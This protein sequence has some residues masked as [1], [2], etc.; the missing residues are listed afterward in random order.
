MKP[1]AF[2]R[3]EIVDGRAHW[4]ATYREDGG[5]PRADIWRDTEWVGQWSW[6]EQGFGGRIQRSRLRV[7]RGVLEKLA[8]AMLALLLLGCSSHAYS[9]GTP[10][11]EDGA[12]GAGGLL[13]VDADVADRIVDTYENDAEPDSAPQGTE[14]CPGSGTCDTSGY[15]VACDATA[16]STRCACIADVYPD[17]YTGEGACVFGGGF[18]Q[19]EQT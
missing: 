9:P 12:A 19:C 14:N 3:Y 11:D 15:C 5:A 4:T 6:T 1:S 17:L 18:C 8:R 13:T 10:G 2:K 16:C 7:P